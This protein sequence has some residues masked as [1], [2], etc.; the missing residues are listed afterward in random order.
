MLE[1]AIIRAVAVNLYISFVTIG[2]F[3]GCEKGFG[4]AHDTCDHDNKVPYQRGGR[5]RHKM[6]MQGV[7]CISY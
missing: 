1:E 5:S 4:L 2:C 3:A 7:C 6:V